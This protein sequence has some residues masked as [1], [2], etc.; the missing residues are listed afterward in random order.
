MKNSLVLLMLMSVLIYSCEKQPSENA[1]TEAGATQTETDATHE[2]GQ[3]AHTESTNK[4]SLDN[5]VKWK[6][7]P[8]MMVHVQQMKTDIAK[9]ATETAGDYKLLADK[10]TKGNDQ[11]IASCTMQ[12][13]AHEELHKWLLPFIDLVGQ[14][15]N[16]T[17]QETANKTFQLV[18]NSMK[19]FDEY[20]E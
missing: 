8:E 10:L 14:F 4:L 16:A 18:Q 1:K 17:D 15:S 5:G 2:D 19:E 7:N 6:V 3:H 11:L 20:F 9:F 12:G 13:A